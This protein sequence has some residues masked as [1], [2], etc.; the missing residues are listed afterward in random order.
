M[1]QLQLPIFPAGTSRITPEL[2]VECRDGQVVYFNGHLPVF[3]HEARDVATFRFFTTQLVINGTVSQANIVR[4]FGVPSTTVKRCVKAF[5]E[6]GP[7]IFY[8]PASGRRKGK[9]LTSERL[10]DVQTALNQGQSVPA[11]SKQLGVLPSTLH[12]A[13]DDGRLK[14][15]STSPD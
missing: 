12:K 7:R 6:H 15:R 11:I 2:A 8:A 10:V 4:A 5:R 1:P 9:K 14:K 3:T 13:I